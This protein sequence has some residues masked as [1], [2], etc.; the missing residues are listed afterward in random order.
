MHKEVISGL[1]RVESRAFA[2]EE[3]EAR[4]LHPKASHRN[5]GFCGVE[6]S[7]LEKKD[8]TATAFGESRE[9]EPR[10]NLL[11]QQL[12][13]VSAES[14]LYFTDTGTREYCKHATI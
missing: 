12:T 10:N 13:K 7:M 6:K 8:M 11:K 4:H 2:S 14:E 3:G 5:D 1:A 9:F